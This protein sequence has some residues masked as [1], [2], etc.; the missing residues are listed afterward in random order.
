MWISRCRRMSQHRRVYSCSALRAHVVFW[1]YGARIWDQIFVLDAHAHVIVC[2]KLSEMRRHYIITW[3]TFSDSTTNGTGS[4]ALHIC[5]LAVFTVAW[6]AN[7]VA[8]ACLCVHVFLHRTSHHVWDLRNV[9]R[10][11]RPKRSVFPLETTLILFQF[12][13]LPKWSKHIWIN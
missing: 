12:L 4:V 3:I 1:C 8:W 7:A 13:L 5:A 11:L 9:L 10:I 6:R 2:Q